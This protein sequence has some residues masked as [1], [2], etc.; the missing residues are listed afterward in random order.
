[1]NSTQFPHFP[2]S[3]LNRRSFLRWTVL[4]SGAAALG[5]PAFL[6]G[7][8]LNNKLN[9]GIIG[10]GGRGGFAVQ[11]SRNENIVALCDVAEDRLNK[12]GERHP[13]ARKY[14]D[15]RKLL[16]EAKDI[17]AI[18]VATAATAQAGLL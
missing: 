16:D 2:S 7:Q 10:A 12:I 15:F 8:N 14:V 9:I 4:T 6:R 3:Q 17:D 11:Q 13:K 18:T 1:M 5:A